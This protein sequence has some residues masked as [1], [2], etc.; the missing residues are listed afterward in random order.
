NHGDGDCV[1]NMDNDGGQWHDVDC[2]TT[3]HF[4]CYNGSSKGFVRVQEKKNWTEAKN[5]CRE[6]HTD[7][8][9]VRNESENNQIQNIIN[10][11]LT[12]DKQAWIGL[13]RFWVWSDN[14]K[15]IFT[16][17]KT[18]EPNIRATNKSIC[19]STG[20]SDEGRWTDEL[21]SDQHLFVC[22]DGE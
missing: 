15:C 8:V 20:I 16:H 5:Y 3:R 7:L 10:Q 21:C 2:S 13:Y 22:Y 9:S 17:W 14:S 4:I 12:S 6:K 1:Y 11:N 19:V 18:N